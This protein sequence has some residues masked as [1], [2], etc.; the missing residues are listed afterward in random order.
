MQRSDPKSTIKMRERFGEMLS[1][2]ESNQIEYPT[3]QDS[4]A[5]II[6]FDQFTRHIAR[7]DRERIERNTRR[8]L[9]VLQCINIDNIDIHKE[10]SGRRTCICIDAF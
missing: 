2:A 6:L 9:G 7:G 4:L 8:A 5:V 10:W 3:L 1:F